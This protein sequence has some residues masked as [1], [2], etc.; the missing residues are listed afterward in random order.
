VRFELKRAVADREI[1]RAFPQMLQRV[2][3][4]VELD[5]HAD[6]RVRLADVIEQARQPVIRR[7][8]LRADAQRPWCLPPA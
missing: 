8:A 4:G 1:E 6:P 5:A 2:E 3:R 7:V